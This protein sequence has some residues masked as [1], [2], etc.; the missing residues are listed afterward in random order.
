MGYRDRDGP[1]FLIAGPGMSKAKEYCLLGCTGRYDVWL[2]I[3]QL[4]ST[5]SWLGPMLS[6]RIG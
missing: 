2:W 5:S 3:G 4:A 1:R 6:L